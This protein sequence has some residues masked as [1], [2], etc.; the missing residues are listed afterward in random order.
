MRRVLGG[1]TGVTGRVLT[2]G[3]AVGLAAG[4]VFGLTACSTETV[5]GNGQTQTDTSN[6][7]LVEIPAEERGEQIVFA[8]RDESGNAVSSLRYEGQ[9]LVVNF[10]YAGCPPCRAEAEFLNEVASGLDPAEAAFI[11][12]NVRDSAETA[13]SFNTEFGVPYHSIIDGQ[14]A[15]VQLAFAGSIPQ[16]AV[17][18]TVVLDRQGRMAA[19]ILGGIPDA[20]ILQ[21]I[22]DDVIAEG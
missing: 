16:S 4:L 22:V 18:V 1:V 12:V 11:G 2:A 8:G 6:Q 9:V 17:P 19:R 15:S 5:Q 10:W 3:V 13:T 20:S 21:T 7:A 14:T